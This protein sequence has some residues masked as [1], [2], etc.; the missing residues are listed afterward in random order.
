M[1]ARVDTVRASMAQEL[2]GYVAPVAAHE[3]VQRVAAIVERNEKAR[4][5]IL[6]ALGWMKFHVDRDLGAALEMMGTLEVEPEHPWH[7]RLQILFA[8]SRHRFAEAVALLQAGIDSDPYS[9]WLNASLAWMYH[10]GGECEQSVLQ[11]ERCLR[12]TPDHA[13]TR[14]FSGMILACQGEVDRALALTGELALQAPYFDMG[15]AAHAYVLACR[16]DRE[17]AGELLEGLQWL[18]RERYVQRSFTAPAYLAL[19]D[20]EAA[21]AELLTADRERCPWVLQ[22]LADPRLHGLRDMSDFKA[23]R[24]RL[25]EM[26]SEAAVRALNPPLG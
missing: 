19:G 10:L 22:L 13:A 9:A 25:E 20:A 12:L 17:Q 21:L 18:G 2:F 5:V 1:Q 16:G 23:M 14:L 15:I 7:R 3:E 26:E 11:V 8:A 6:P 4:R 24:A